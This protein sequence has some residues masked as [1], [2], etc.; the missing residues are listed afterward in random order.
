MLI[1][2]TGLKPYCFLFPNE[3]GCS[4]G[5]RYNKNGEKEMNN[6]INYKK[7]NFQKNNLQKISDFV[8]MIVFIGTVLYLLLNFILFY[9]KKRF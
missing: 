5:E 9:K 6:F 2:G 7:I 3:N 1:S 8:S 4:P